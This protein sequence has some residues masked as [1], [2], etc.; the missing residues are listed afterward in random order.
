VRHI[1]GHRNGSNEQLDQVPYSFYRCRSSKYFSRV[2]NFDQTRPLAIRYGHAFAICVG[3][4]PMYTSAE[5]RAQAEEKLAQAQWD[6]RNRNRLITAAEAWL[7]LA[8]QLRRLEASFGPKRRSSRTTA[9]WIEPSG[10]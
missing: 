3:G 7:F 6:D 2:F 5:C 9:W 1:A 4:L 10:P 8:S